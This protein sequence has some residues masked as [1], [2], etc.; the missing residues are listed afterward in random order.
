[1]KLRRS[2]PLLLAF[3]TASPLAAQEPILFGNAVPLPRSLALAVTHELLLGGKWEEARDLA[4]Q[5]VPVL[6][7]DFDTDPAPAATAL[8]LLALAEAGAGDRDTALCHWE[9]AKSL[10][11]KL[12]EAD[13][14]LYGK[15]GVFLRDTREPKLSEKARKAMEKAHEEGEETT[16]PEI[17]DSSRKP[18]YTDAAREANVQGRVV[19][20]SI[21]G[22]DGRISHVRTLENLP[23]GLGLQAMEAVYHWRFKPARFG[24]QPVKVY[25]NLTINFT[26]PQPSESQNP[27]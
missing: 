12:S 1:M 6:A 26:R 10:N 19:I 24:R 7:G 8:A 9:V 23:K 14:S 25:Y 11:E 16:R 22:E 27:G 18:A 3:L 21:I 2:F 17:V 4:Q 20:E 5:A 13:L 15:P